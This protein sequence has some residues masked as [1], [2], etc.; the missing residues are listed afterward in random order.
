M[1]TEQRRRLY[2]TIAIAPSLIW[3]LSDALWLPPF[4]P[5]SQVRFSSQCINDVNSHSMKLYWAIASEFGSWPA[6]ELI[7]R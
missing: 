4:E 1:L 6:V 2:G 3:E 7:N 5:H